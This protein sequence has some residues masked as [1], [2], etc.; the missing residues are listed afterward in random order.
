MAHHQGMILV[1]IDNT[2][3]D[4]I[5]QTRFHADLRVRA[6]E[7][8]LFERIP[9]APL[10]VEGTARRLAMPLQLTTRPRT[11]RP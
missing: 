6:T 5:M 8:V 7:P 4:N 2:L 10:L 3:H 9:V 11:P 1:A